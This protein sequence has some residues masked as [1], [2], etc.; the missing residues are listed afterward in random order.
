MSSGSRRPLRGTQDHR[1]R[2]RLCEHVEGRV[3]QRGEGQ[4]QAL[5][6]EV[7][8]VEEAKWKANEVK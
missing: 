3:R 1:G 2:V 7:V 6:V 4:G 8:G 5:W